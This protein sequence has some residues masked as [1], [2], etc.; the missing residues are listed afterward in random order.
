MKEQVLLPTVADNG[1][2]QSDSP[3]FNLHRDQVS[4]FLSV[5]LFESSHK[6]LY[7][8]L[9]SHIAFLDDKK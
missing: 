7:P 3:K 9:Q 8:L 1:E 2:L 6:H 4:P 5:I